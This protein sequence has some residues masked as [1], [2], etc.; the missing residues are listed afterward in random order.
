[1]ASIWTAST[2][3]DFKEI[4]KILMQW[5]GYQVGLNKTIGIYF[6]IRGF[7][8]FVNSGISLFRKLRNDLIKKIK[9]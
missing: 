5:P 7:P 6:R 4:E 3:G 8:F 2:D 9:K 1:M